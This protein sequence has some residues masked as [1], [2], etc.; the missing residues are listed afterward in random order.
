MDDAI[1][2]VENVYRRLRENALLPPE[3]RRPIFDVVYDASREIRSSVVFATAIIVLVF[4]PL[5]FLS[6]IEGRLLR[7]LGVAYVTSI[8]ASLLVA[9]TIT[10]VLCMLLL[11]ANAKAHAPEHDSFV[12]R[13]LKRAYRP[14]RR[15]DACASRSRS[16]SRRSRAPWPP[17]SA[18]A[19][20]RSHRFLPEFNEGSL[21]IAAATAPGTSLE[22]SD[23]IVSRLETLPRSRTPR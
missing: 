3:Q 1:I 11:G 20:V 13:H 6:G 22:T 2:D 9:L 10:P 5:F 16:R 4:A 12:A 7:P 23:E 17:S 21:N 19:L 15:G 14:R 18:L 8:G